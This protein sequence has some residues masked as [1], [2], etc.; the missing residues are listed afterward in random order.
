MS[1]YLHPALAGALVLAVTTSVAAPT[2]AAPPRVL[3]RTLSTVSEAGRQVFRLDDR[4]GDGLAWWPDVAWHGADQQTYEVIDFR[5]L[6]FRSQDPVQRQR[7]VKRLT[8]RPGGSVGLWVGNTS[9][10]D[11]ANV[12]IAPRGQGAATAPAAAPAVPAGAANLSGTYVGQILPDGGGDPFDGRFVIV[13]RG[14]AVEISLGPNA[15][16]LVSGA[17]VTRTSSALTFEADPPGETPNH[18]AFAVEITG[19]ALT[20]TLVQTR[21][22][23]TRKGRLVFTKQ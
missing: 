16:E 2:A 8:L 6:N 7:A 15:D 4:D 10:G 18:L 14:G 11:F 19:D 23:Q 3:N 9:P 22:G 5:P 1:S 17:K 13:D 21:D 12:T 20:G